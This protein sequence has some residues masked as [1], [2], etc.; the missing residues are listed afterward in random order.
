VRVPKGDITPAQFRSL[1]ELTVKYSSEG[2]L[3][4][5]NEQNLV[6]RFVPTTAV[7]DLHRELTAIGLGQGNAMTL[8]DVL[9]CPG[10]SSC[11]IAV[12]NSKALGGILTDHFDAKPELVAQA[13]GLDVK[14]SGCPNGCGQHYSSVIGLQG[15]MRK[16]DGKPVPQYFVYVGGGFAADGPKFGRIAGKV[17]ARR[18]AAAIERLV[19]MYSEQKQPG[20]TPLA[21]FTRIETAKV[22]AQIKDLTELD[23]KTATERDFFD[24]GEDKAFEL[25]EMEG[26]CA[27]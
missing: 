14:I 8:A 12:T 26:E 21:F 3:R 10:A 19:A 27:A 25:V 5:T 13:P 11:K 24:L 18:A 7:A 15:G 20:E 16:I 17:P 23:E 22:T 1:A 2:E 6:I 4:T 9:S